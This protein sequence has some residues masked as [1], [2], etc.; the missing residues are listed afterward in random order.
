M[1]SLTFF[2]K[3]TFG[4]LEKNYYICDVNNKKDKKMINDGTTYRNRQKSNTQNAN[5]GYKPKF[6][7]RDVICRKDDPTAQKT[8]SGVVKNCL[9]DDCYEFE[10]RSSIWMCVQVDSLFELQREDDNPVES[11]MHL[12]RTPIAKRKGLTLSKED[13]EVWAEEFEKWLRK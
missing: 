12:L 2:M 4:R 1:P 10:D 5:G 7:K 11:F 3:R 8:V 9:G 6:K 13:C